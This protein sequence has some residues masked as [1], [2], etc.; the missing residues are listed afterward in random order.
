MRVS[1]FAS[2]FSESNRTDEPVSRTGGTTLDLADDSDQED[3]E[4]HVNEEAVG[5][6]VRKIPL[7]IF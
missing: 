5:D 3:E 1:V 4:N 2:G 6:A 7:H